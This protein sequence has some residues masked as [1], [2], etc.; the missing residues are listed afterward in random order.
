MEPIF[1]NRKR[2]VFNKE[3]NM[4]DLQKAKKIANQIIE[5]K[6]EAVRT[7]VNEVTYSIFGR[8]RKEY[9]HSGKWNDR[10]SKIGAYLGF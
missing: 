2:F 7:G 9:Y 10:P 1:Q 6:K 3:K 8:T 5:M 4:T